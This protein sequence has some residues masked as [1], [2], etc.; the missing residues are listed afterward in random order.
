MITRDI[1]TWG[2]DSRQPTVETTPVHS[3]NKYSANEENS[4]DKQ[5]INDA[6]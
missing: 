3:E 5:F 2:R 4:G 6:V 1:E